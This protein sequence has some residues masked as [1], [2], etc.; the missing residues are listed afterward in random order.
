MILEMS[1][2]SGRG[3]ALSLT[4]NPLFYMTNFDGQTMAQASLSSI[5]TSGVDGDTVTNVQAQPR[6]IVI[7]LRIKEGVNV[8]EA[9]RKVLETVK[10]K[11]R[12][13]IVWTQDAR[14]LVISGIVES[15]TMPRWDSAVI[16]QI[17][18]YCEQ[19]F[20]QD[21]FSV[22]D[23]INE[24]QNEHYFTTL[25]NDMLYFPADGVPFGIIDESRTKS[26]ANA[27][28]V[29]VG[30]YIVIR[31]RGTVTNPII[32]DTDGNFF[33]VGYGTGD[34]QVVLAAG[35]TITIST[36][37]G[38]KTVKKGSVSL[39]EYI[40]PGSQWLQM[41]AGANQFTINSDDDAIDNMTF[42]LTYR[43]RYI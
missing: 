27:G 19:P 43:Q 34:K 4:S 14:E 26:L 28:D 18:L 32:Y 9:K 36:H 35:D 41:R 20:W 40:K 13:T 12:G 42:N 31:A 37:K 2:V 15:V 1:F 24:V 6:S 39:Y 30:L 3:D 33:G 23:E 8:E 11:Q 10:I 29:D 38:N 17:A 21:A 22:V 5:V 16:M 25:L 7:D